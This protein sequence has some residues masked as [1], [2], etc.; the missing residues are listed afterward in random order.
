MAKN[1]ARKFSISK[2]DKKDIYDLKPWFHDFSALFNI[3]TVFFRSVA[4]KHIIKEILTL[5][6]GKTYH[7]PRNQESKQEFLIPL[8]FYATLQLNRNKK[9]P[10]SMC[11]FFCADCHY[12]FWVKK[13]C[14]IDK[15]VGYDFSE[16][17]IR[18][19][20]LMKNLLK[21]NNMEFFVSDIHEV[22][23]D[24]KYDI[25]LNAGGLY[26]V[27]DPKKIMDINY[28]ICNKYSIVQTIVTDKT[29]DPN[30]FAYPAPDG[31]H[32]SR[33]SQ[34]WM[35]NLIKQYSWKIIFSARNTLHSN[36]NIHNTGSVYYLLEKEM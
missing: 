7:H 3:N 6:G 12:S 9:K 13:Y 18:Q 31:L 27:E 23:T 28:E 15:I 19:A 2:K 24:T 17:A 32:L 35:E 20:K 33:F 22:P 21:L 16:L 14:N 26:H 30:Y 25:V 36:K 34:K 1:K 8:L 4:V 11:E 10:T 29:E 5:M